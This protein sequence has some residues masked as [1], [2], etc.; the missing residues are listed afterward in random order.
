MKIKNRKI[1]QAEIKVSNNIGKFFDMQKK[2]SLGQALSEWK[3]KRLRAK[4]GVC[5]LQCNVIH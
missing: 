2:T 1:E 3:L 5:A 4:I